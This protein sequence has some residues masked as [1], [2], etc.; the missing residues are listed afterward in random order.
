MAIGNFIHALNMHLFILELQNLPNIFG[1]YP[2][3]YRHSVSRD[4]KYNITDILTSLLQSLMKFLKT[5]PVTADH[6]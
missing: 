2:A 6:T 1:A 5:W 4:T 3:I